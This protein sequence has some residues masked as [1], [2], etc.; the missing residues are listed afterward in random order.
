MSKEIARHETQDMTKI[1][2]RSLSEIVE[3]KDLESFQKLLNLTPPKNWVE[4]HP[5]VKNHLYIPISRTE[6]SLDEMFFGLWK[7]TNYETKIIGNEIAGSILLHV[8]HPILKE[9]LTRT[10]AAGV[11][12][13]YEAWE[14]DE[15][16]K[17]ITGA[18]GKW[19]RRKNKPTDIDAKILNTV[20]KDY[21]HLLTECTK[22]AAKKFGKR[23]G[24]DLNREKQAGD[25][26]PITEQL[27][28]VEVEEVEQQFATAST[29][30]ELRTLWSKNKH[31]HNNIQITSLFFKRYQ[32]FQK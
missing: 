15:K 7:T 19:V 12:I 23:F 18:D 13:Q 27:S 5:H 24:R 17:R 3:A 8:Y 21:P 10:G 22:N 14:T 20:V 25:Y 6:M 9:W 2:G 29:E 28:V 11:M 1:N 32:Q 26:F 16:G 4:E 31:W 30:T